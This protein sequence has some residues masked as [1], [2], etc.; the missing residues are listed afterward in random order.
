MTTAALDRAIPLSFDAVYE[1][2]FDYVYRIVA[3]LSGTS[4]CEDLVQDVFLVVHRRLPEFEGRAAMTTWLFQI[5]YRVVGAHVRKE[6]LRRL[7]ARALFLERPEP[8]FQD[9]DRAA[10]VRRALE[11]LSWKKRT[12]LVLFEIE[13][14]S[15]DRIAEE[16]GIPVDTVYSRLHNARRD[17]AKELR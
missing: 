8:S 9:P 1:A 3:R 7:L 4:A 6:R 2:H 10:A 15:C 5:A 12:V 16:L 11:S 14:W 13:G 17:L